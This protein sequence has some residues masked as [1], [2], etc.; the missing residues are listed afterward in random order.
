MN[1]SILYLALIF[2]FLSLQAECGK[3][4][5]KKIVRNDSVFLSYW[6]FPENSYWIYKDSL[7]GEFD[8]SIITATTQYLNEG[9]HDNTEWEFHAISHF[10]KGKSK[11][12]VG[13][14]REYDGSQYIYFLDQSWDG[15]ELAIRFFYTKDNSTTNL[16][17]HLFQAHY[18]SITINS[19]NYYDVYKMTNI[20][21]QGNDDTVRIE[22]YARN[23][24]IIKRVYENGRVW[25]LDK[26][27]I[28]P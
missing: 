1:K 24:G 22:Y 9:N 18:D 28:A 15:G 4:E 14:P 7:N 11:T 23:I 13:Q 8:T 20:D 12:N 17:K 3:N 10:N 2:G 16:E 25:E 5:P 21:N 6:Y 19:I 27:Y 26:Y